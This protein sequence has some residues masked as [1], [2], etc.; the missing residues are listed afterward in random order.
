MVDYNLSAVS[1]KYYKFLIITVKCGTILFI[2]LYD[3]EIWSLAQREER[4][5]VLANMF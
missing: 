2:H 4:A 5:K 3:C 1:L